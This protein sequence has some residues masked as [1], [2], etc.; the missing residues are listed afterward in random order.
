MTPEGKVKKSIKKVL[1]PRLPA[2]YY[3]MPVPSG[4][5]KSTL[6]FVGCYY[7]RFFSIEAKAQGEAPNERQDGIIEDMIAA[8]ATVFVIDGDDGMMMLEDWLTEIERISI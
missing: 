4:Y 2:L 8:G 1:D 7:G 6:D 3:H 5:G